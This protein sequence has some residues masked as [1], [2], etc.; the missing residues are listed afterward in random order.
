M[1]TGRISRRT[2]PGRFGAA[3][4]IG[5]PPAGRGAAGT[6]AAAAGAGKPA[7]GGAVIA[8]DSETGAETA[9]LSDM[10]EVPL[11]YTVEPNGSVI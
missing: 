3:T 5:A 7:G 6:P 11:K 2:R 9:G 1:T 8:R 4:A 10:Q